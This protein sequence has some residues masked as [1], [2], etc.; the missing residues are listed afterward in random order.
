[1]IINEKEAYELYVKACHRKIGEFVSEFNFNEWLVMGRPKS[2]Y[3]KDG[4]WP[5]PWED[6]Q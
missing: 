1:M 2:Q 4:Y 5:T 3:P 6:K